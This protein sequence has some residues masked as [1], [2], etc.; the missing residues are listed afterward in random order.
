MIK[1]VII[2]LIIILIILAYFFTRKTEVTESE[3]ARIS[4][5][6][7][8]IYGWKML[9]DEALPKFNNINDANEDWIWDRVQQ[10]LNKYE[11]TDEDYLFSYSQ[12][13]K[14]QKYLFGDKLKK[15]FPVA[16][17]EFLTYDEE[18]KSFL[19][20]GIG[21]GDEEDCFVISDITK[22]AN[23]Y[24][25]EIIEYIVDHSNVHEALNDEEATGYEFY[26]KKIDETQVKTY[27][28][29]FYNE[30]IDE[31]E[32]TSVDGKEEEIKQYVLENKEQFGITSVK[33]EIDKSTN[34]VHVISIE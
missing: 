1:K 9:Y 21:L 24:T 29:E 33:L 8:E 18:T 32:Y 19:S 15:Q 12:I 26:L 30:Y 2:I 14:A 27:W 13:E 31:E 28:A 7:E 3:R 16:G 20:S 11:N 25:V 4:V 6:L 5:Y 22:R 23:K 34:L 10:R 17:T